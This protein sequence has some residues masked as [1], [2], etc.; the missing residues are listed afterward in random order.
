MPNLKCTT[1]LVLINVYPCN[2][3]SQDIEHFCHSRK[4]P[5]TLPC[6]YCSYFYHHKFSPSITLYK[7]N[8][9]VCYFVSGSFHSTWSL[10]GF[11]LIA[12]CISIPFF[13][14]AEQYSFIWIIPQFILDGYLGSFQLGTSVKLL[15]T[16]FCMPFCGHTFS[17][18]LKK[19]LEVEFLGHS[20][21]TW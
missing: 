2:Y 20:T 19:Y 15:W 12:G 5:Y 13:L 3:T 1:W 9:S 8:N 17:F 11:A 18:L 10:G 21:D 6:K 16:S 7:K 14:L 4:L